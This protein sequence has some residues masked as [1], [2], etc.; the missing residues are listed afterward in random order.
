MSA[1]ENVYSTDKDVYFLLIVGNWELA[2]KAIPRG[3]T[4]NEKLS[5]LGAAVRGGNMDAVRHMADM[6]AEIGPTDNEILTAME[7]GCGCFQ[8][9]GQFATVQYIYNRFK[10]CI[11]GEYGSHCLAVALRICGNSE[12]INWLIG[13][14]AEDRRTIKY[15]PTWR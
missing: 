4:R 11:S 5:W 1:D 9:R 14:G 12:I 7:S 13:L 6:V 8:N 3:I 10:P 15:A 2:Q